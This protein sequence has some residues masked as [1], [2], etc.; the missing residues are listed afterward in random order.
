M[1]SIERFGPYR[2][3]RELGAGGMGRVHLAEREDLE[4]PVVVKRMNAE[5]AADARFR[6]RLLREAEVAADLQ[7]PNVV[8][9]LDTGVIDDQVYLVM[10]YVPGSSLAGVLAANRPEPL[11]LVPV[12]HAVAQACDGLAYVHMFTEPRSGKWLQLVHRDVSLDNLLVSYSGEV[13]LAD[14]GIVKTVDGT[15]TTSG[16]IMGK[17][18]YMSP[19]Q[20][21]DE[22]LDARS[23]VYS[24]GVC[25]FELV[26]GKRPLPASRARS[27]MEAVLYDVPPSL[28]QFRPDAPERL[29][30]LVAR[31][32]AKER[33]ERPAG[34]EEVAKELRAVLAGRDESPLFPSR[35]L[36]APP[37]NRARISPSEAAT[38]VEVQAATKPQRLQGP[39]AEAAAPG[40]EERGP[41]ENAARK[42]TPVPGAEVRRPTPAPDARAPAP[43]LDADS[44]EPASAPGADAR[45]PTPAPEAAARKLT[46]V[47]EVDSRKPTSALKVDSRKPTPGPVPGPGPRLRP[48]PQS[49]RSSSSPPTRSPSPEDPVFSVPTAA[50]SAPTEPADSVF[51]VPTRAPSAPSEPA[52]SVFSVPTRAASASLHSRPTRIRPPSSEEEI[53]STRRLASPS[54]RAS[55]IRWAALG[56]LALLGAAAF[57]WWA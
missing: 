9:V 47:L 45:K 1:G 23:D 25:L 50:P 5:L 44:R 55:L 18:G 17:L 35:L 48:T 4:G 31:M 32:L 42:P 2:I 8:R 43:S 24:L 46:P 36:D 28:E 52:D 37:R 21:R 41:G 56:A 7:H 34:C 27:V 11:P 54:R 40:A 12:L 13:K 19:E 39:K 57:W 20:L 16:V 30:A 51:S 38:E 22:T 26:A 29:V 49:E 53:Q 6:R 33:K 3:L 14:F 15:Q 10:E